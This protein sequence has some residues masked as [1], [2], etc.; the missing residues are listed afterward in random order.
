MCQCIYL[1][2]YVY[3]ESMCR[4]PKLDCLHFG[5]SYPLSQ[6]SLCQTDSMRNSM[7]G[8]QPAE[9]GDLVDALG[10]GGSQFMHSAFSS[11]LNFT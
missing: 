3:P 7:T 2:M 5:Q 6:E 9:A 11:A 1:Y 4:P 8:R 10:R